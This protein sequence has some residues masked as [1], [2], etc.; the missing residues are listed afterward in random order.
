M[1]NIIQ[2]VDGG[3]C[4]NVLCMLRARI[5][6]VDAIR[7]RHAD[8]EPH[9]DVRVPGCLVGSQDLVDRLKVGIDSDHIRSRQRPEPE[10]PTLEQHEV[11]PPLHLLTQMLR[12]RQ[13]P[14]FAPLHANERSA[15]STASNGQLY[16][17]PCVRVSTVPS[18]CMS[19]LVIARDPEGAS[20]RLS[21]AAERPQRRAARQ[22]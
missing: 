3:T 20:V 22:S 5:A 15:L 19:G 7:V 14:R 10:H 2:E 17:R 9:I 1:A 4:L 8:D 6:L 11:H 13:L 16:L 18:P 12:M 21:A